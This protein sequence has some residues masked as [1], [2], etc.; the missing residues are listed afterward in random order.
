MENILMAQ[1]KQD[2]NI[3]HL[4]S[5]VDV[6]TTHDKLLEAQITKQTNS[7][8][9]PPNQLP[10][11]LEPNPREHCNCVVLSSGLEGSVGARLKKEGEENHD[12]SKRSMT[13]NLP[14]LTPYRTPLPFL[15]KRKSDEHETA[16]LIEECSAAIQNQ[17]PLK[18]K[19][20]DSVSVPYLIGNVS[21]NRVSCNLGS[22]VSSMPH[23]IF[24]R[25]DLGKL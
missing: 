5:K 15:H 4:A 21:I 6:L 1:Q 2:E 3:K 18:L 13:S 8:P 17:L 11:Q 20:P 10:I 9:T 16:A 7:S 24:K 22:S 19:D 25:L 14:S 23:S 12:E